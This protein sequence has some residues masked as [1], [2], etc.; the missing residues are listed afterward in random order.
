MAPSWLANPSACKAHIDNK[1]ECRLTVERSDMKTKPKPQEPQV[2]LVGEDGTIQPMSELNAK[3]LRVA[4]ARHIHPSDLKR[5]V[6]RLTKVE[7]LR[8]LRPA[9]QLCSGKS[10]LDMLWEELDAIVER[11]MAG[12]ASEEDKGRAQ[13]TAYAIAVIEN[14]Y[15]P[16]IERI[17]DEAMQRWERDNE[18]G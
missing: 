18:E 16:N 12:A 1:G 9:S 3:H 4:L 15:L 5:A 17:R 2:A 10:I 6:K 14:P 8:P 7:G 13:G 11:L